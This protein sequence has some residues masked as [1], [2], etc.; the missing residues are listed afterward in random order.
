MTSSYSYDSSGIRTSKLVSDSV[1]YSNERKDYTTID[2]RITSETVSG[3][4]MGIESYDYT[5]Y[6]VYNESCEVIGFKY[7]YLDYANYPNWVTENYSYVN[8]DFFGMR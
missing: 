7:K 4:G 2:G 3:G 5:V 6:Y 1:N 8:V